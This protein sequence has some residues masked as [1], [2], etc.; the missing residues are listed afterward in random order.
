DDVFLASLLES[1][2]LEAAIGRTAS[3]VYSLL[4]KTTD[5]DQRELALV[6]AQGELVAPSFTFEVTRVR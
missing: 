2:S 6:P 5:L 3:I 1:G 4:K